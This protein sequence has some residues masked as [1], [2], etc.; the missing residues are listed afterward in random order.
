MSTYRNKA[1]TA[2]FALDRANHDLRV[3]GVRHC[4]WTN[5]A[6]GCVEQGRADCGVLR[7]MLLGRGRGVQ[8]CEGRFESRF[9]LCG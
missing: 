4:A 3:V 1:L 9:R 5:R 6:A 7:R 2:A 8:A